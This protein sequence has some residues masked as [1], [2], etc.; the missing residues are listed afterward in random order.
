MKRIILAICAFCDA[1]FGSGAAPLGPGERSPGTSG[2]SRAAPLLKR[3]VLTGWSVS[4]IVI[5]ALLGA[6]SSDSSALPF[7][8][9]ME[10]YA[11]EALAKEV[12]P[13]ITSLTRDTTLGG[14]HNTYAKIV[15]EISNTYRRTGFCVAWT[16]NYN[17]DP[18]HNQNVVSHE[19]CL[20]TQDREGSVLMWGGLTFGVKV[21]VTYDGIPAADVPW[22]ER[23]VIAF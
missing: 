13:R 6:P 11:A 15:W 7:Q 9:A 5:L 14:K 21:K 18:T 3:R 19:V 23:K 10:K 1:G 4:G 12:A 8:E 20:T 17:D 2:G 16:N 22:S